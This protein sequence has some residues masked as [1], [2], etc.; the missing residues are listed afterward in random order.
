MPDHPGLTVVNVI[1]PFLI[2]LQENVHFQVSQQ[3]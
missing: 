2:G 1:C 3:E